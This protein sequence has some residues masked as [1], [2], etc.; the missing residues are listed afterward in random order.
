MPYFP[1][2]KVVG[3]HLPAMIAG[4]AKA[5]GPWPGRHQPG[6]WAW[7]AGKAVFL[8]LVCQLGL[9]LSA[10][11]VHALTLKQCV[12]LALKNNPDLQKQQMNLELAHSDLSEQKSRNF[13]KLDMVSSYTHYNLPRTLAPMTPASIMNDP[14]SVATTE[15]LF[16]A[17]LV[18]EV[19]L[20]TGFAQTRSIEIAAL[21]KEMARASLK[22]SRQQLIYNVKALYVN[23]LAQQSQGKAQASYVK[24]LQRLHDDIAYELKLGK[25]ARVDLLKAAADLEKA[26]AKMDRIA[27]NI[28]TM[29]AALASLIDVER[30]TE[31]EDIDPTRQPMKFIE[32]DFAGRIKEL[33][34]LKVAQLEIEKSKLQIDRVSG[35][36]Y[37]QIV[38]SMGYGYN[39]GPND[40]SNKYSGDWRDQEVWQA[41]LKLKWNIFDFGTQR[42]KVQ[43]AKIRE[44][45]SRYQQRKTELELRRAL[46]EAATKIN[47]ALTEF[48]S[49][50][51]ELA[52]TRETEA[53]EQM[54]FKQGAADINDLLYA[55][56]RNQLALS[57]FINAGYSYMISRFYL[58]YLLES[59]EDR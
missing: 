39:F 40:E 54:R 5:P 33:Q 29:K 14:T 6:R 18:Y 36:W 20:F 16:G 46:Q 11:G 2:R 24:A 48:N 8:L 27:A 31:L 50:K 7:L 25:K 44:R 30:I 38:L 51:A 9:A 37:P 42:S 47:T 10:P 52:M 34:R 1:M 32:E 23:I 13:G 17:G 19:A 12:E 59:G 28:K 3:G 45:Q 22:L 55:K 58:D 35:E 4:E 41:G 21:Q 43:K 56:A 26:K 49:A 53:I 57:R 15:D